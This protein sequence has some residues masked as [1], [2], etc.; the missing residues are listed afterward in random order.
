MFSTIFAI[1]KRANF[2]KIEIM[3]E[4][5]QVGIDLE[6]DEITAQGHY[7]NLAIISHGIC[8]GFCRDVTWYSQSEG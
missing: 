3:S 1:R 5:K 2:P 7:S 4:M 6:L 8:C